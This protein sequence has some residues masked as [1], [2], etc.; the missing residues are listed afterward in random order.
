[1]VQAYHELRDLAAAN[2]VRFLFEAAVTP[3]VA[4]V[5]SAAVTTAY[6]PLGTS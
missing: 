2:R 3:A 5:A 4:A 6:G 1:V